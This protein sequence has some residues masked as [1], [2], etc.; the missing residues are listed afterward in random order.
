MKALAA[1]TKLG[2]WERARELRCWDLDLG[3]R[4]VKDV[5]SGCREALKHIWIAGCK[6]VDLARIAKAKSECL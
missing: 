4:E 6:R 3:K 2:R 5:L 1:A